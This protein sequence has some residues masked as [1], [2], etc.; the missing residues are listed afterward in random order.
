MINCVSNGKDMKIH[1]I[2]GMIKK[3]LNEILSNAI[4]MYKDESILS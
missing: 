3:I 1:L 2:V 4:S